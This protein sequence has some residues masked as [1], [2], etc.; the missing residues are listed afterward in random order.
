[1]TQASASMTEGPSTGPERPVQRRLTHSW[2][3]RRTLSS[4][5]LTVLAI[6][7]SV[8]ATLPLFSVLFMLIKRGVETLD[9]SLFTELTQGPGMPGGGI[10]NA[11]VGSLVVVG[12]ASLLS[13]PFG[14][15][16]AVYLS[17]WG[18]GSRLASAVRFGGKV[19][20]GLPS[21]L[22]GVYAYA[23]VV[24]ALGSFNA[25]AGGVALGILMMPTVMLTAEEALAMVPNN[26]RMAA[27]G[28]GANRTQT[29][30][31]VV[32]PRAMPGILTGVMLAVARAM[33]ETAP[34]LLTALFSDYWFSGEL[35]QP[36]ASLAVLIYNYSGS[37]FD[38]QVQLAWAASTVLVVLVLAFN[39]IAQILTR[40]ADER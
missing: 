30:L 27:L 21:I 32:I 20:T 4:A 37:P 12:V 5:A 35:D 2:T 9:V 17:E 34:L 29:V 15:L 14:L 7:L 33:G 11:I 24:T 26:M 40:R 16:A 31:R 18:K 28:M 6:A 19:L 8:L 36:I 25:F 23:L 38:R 13:V 22:A 10:G 3:D 39:V 1:M